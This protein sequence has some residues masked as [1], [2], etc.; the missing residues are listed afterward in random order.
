M[1]MKPPTHLTDRQEQVLM[2]FWRVGRREFAPMNSDDIAKRLGVSKP[3]IG[4]TLETFMRSGLV[5]AQN[6]GKNETTYELSQG[7]RRLAAALLALHVSAHR[8]DF[9]CRDIQFH[10]TMPAERMGAGQDA[11]KPRVVSA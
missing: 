7:G 9:R 5:E 4:R 2:S 3:Q 11:S 8:F 10:D 1:V 6:K